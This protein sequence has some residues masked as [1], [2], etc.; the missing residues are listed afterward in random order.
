[1]PHR[2]E[3]VN[4]ITP[5][6]EAEKAVLKSQENSEVSF[7]NVLKT[8]LEKV[9]KAELEADLKTEMLANGQIDQLHDVMI[10]AQKASLTVETAVQIQQKV[11]DTYNEIMRMQI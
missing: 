1:V 5:L 11:V 3:S 8:A 9:N 10:S 2:I 6:R 7:K 4:Q